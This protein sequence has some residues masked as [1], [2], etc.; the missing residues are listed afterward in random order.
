M[1]LSSNMAKTVV[2]VYDP[3]KADI[4]QREKINRLIKKGYKID[5]RVKL[6]GNVKTKF[7]IHH[8]SKTT[9]KQFKNVYL[10]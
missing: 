5:G 2:F 3:D 1:I 7:E 10:K 9:I 4:P 8:P 6:D